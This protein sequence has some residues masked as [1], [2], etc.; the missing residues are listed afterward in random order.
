VY[1][2]LFNAIPAARNFWIQNQNTQIQRRNERRKRWQLALTNAIQSND[3]ISKKLRAAKKMKM[4][5]KQIDS[6]K[7]IVYDTSRPM[8]ENVFKKEQKSLEDFDRLLENDEGK[9][10]Q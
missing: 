1:A 4:K 6:Q 5:V 8:E 2:V 9:S 7:D 3:R 10:F